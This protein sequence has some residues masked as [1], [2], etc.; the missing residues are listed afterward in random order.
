[1]ASPLRH[2]R[3]AHAARP[4]RRPTGIRRR[5]RDRWL[6]YFDGLGIEGIATGGVVLRRRAGENWMRAD[7]IPADRLRPAGDQIERVFAAGDLLTAMRD[8]RELLGVRVA[9]TPRAVLEQ[10]SVLDHGEW[11]NAGAVLRLEE[12]L[13]F[14]A[15]LDGGTAGLVAAFDGTRTVREVAAELARLEGASREAIEQAALPIVAELLAAGFLEVRREQLAAPYV[16]R[17]P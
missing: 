13:G 1:V 10:S 3:A 2:E 8:E 4:R 9:L 7:R 16:L 15:A 6:A 14:E 5:D 17:V 11:R 12:G